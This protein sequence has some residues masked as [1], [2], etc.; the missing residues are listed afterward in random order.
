[1]SEDKPGFLGQVMGVLYQPRKI[2]STVDESDLTKGLIV[3]FLMVILASYSSTLY[4][5]KIPLSV[6]SSQL[7]GVDT[8]QFEGT[9]GI[10][11]GIGSAVT[12]IIGWVASTVLMHGL[13]RLSGGGGSIKRFFALHGFAS[14]PSL[15]NQVVRIA[16]ASIIDSASLSSYFVTYRDM[17]NKMLKAFLGTNLFNIWGLATVVLLVFAVEDN[18]KTSSTRSA[19]VVLLPSLIYFL[20]NFFM[21]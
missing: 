3:M 8:S 13:G 17:E 14:V 10:F 5:D 20:I 15:L 19:M 12:I 6:L 18:Y 9:M 21:G 11:A 4:M 2:F 16:D 1:M 7:E